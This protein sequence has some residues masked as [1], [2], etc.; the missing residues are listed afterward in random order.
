M[1]K[2]KSRF[3]K[4]T[5]PK[6]TSD[7]YRPDLCHFH[8]TPFTFQHGP[9]IVNKYI[10]KIWHKRVVIQKRKILRKS[11]TY[12]NG[13]AHNPCSHMIQTNSMERVAVGEHTLESM[14]LLEWN[15]RGAG[16]P[17]QFVYSR[18][19]LVPKT[20][21]WFLSLKQKAYY[22]G[23]RNESILGDPGSAQEWI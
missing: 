6:K 15:C 22:I 11:R 14:R 9:C 2:G 19:L 23:L 16:I 13:P 8:N 5:N 10:T 7:W 3:N 20:H 21:T 18:N 12:N 4:A 1:K 17:R